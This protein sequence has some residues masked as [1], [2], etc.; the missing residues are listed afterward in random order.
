MLFTKK[1]VEKE[2][3]KLKLVKKIEQ[4]HESFMIHKRFILQHW[5]Y[6]CTVIL[7]IGNKIRTSFK[8]L[9]SKKART[10]QLKITSV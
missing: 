3:Q 9:V 1:D 2:H 10:R 5:Y 6:H 4:V 7:E 8:S